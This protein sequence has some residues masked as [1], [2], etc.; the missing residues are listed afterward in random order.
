VPSTPP[1]AG[2][3]APPKLPPPRVPSIPPVAQS[4]FVPAR[5]ER[6]SNKGGVIAA[7][8]AAVLFAVAGL[9]GLAYLGVQRYAER[10]KKASIEKQEEIDNAEK[11]VLPSSTH[12]ATADLVDEDFKIKI[13]WPGKGAKVLRSDDASRLFPFSVGGILQEGGCSLVVTADYSPKAELDS[14]AKAHYATIPGRHVGE[15]KTEA[16]KFEGRDALRFAIQTDHLGMLATYDNLIFERDGWFL[17][18]VSWSLPNAK[19][20]LDHD[21]SVDLLEGTAAGRV[22]S[23]PTLNESRP[24]YRVRG[25]VFESAAHRLRVTAPDGTSLTTGVPALTI[26]SEAAVVVSAKGIE[27][28]VASQPLPPGPLEKHQEGLLKAAAEGMN[29]KVPAAPT[30]LKRVG[31]AAIDL[32]VL[33]GPAPYET[34][35]GSTALGGRVLAVRAVYAPSLRS[36]AEELIF[37]T[38]SSTD[39]LTDDAAAALR[40]ELPAIDPSRLVGPDR[41]LRGGKLVH[42][43]AGLTIPLPPDPTLPSLDDPWNTAPVSL[44]LRRPTW[45]IGTEVFVSP[46]EADV[47][48]AQRRVAAIVLGLSEGDVEAVRATAPIPGAARATVAYELASGVAGRV[49]IVTLRGNGHAVHVATNGVQKWVEDAE[50]D[51]KSFLT[52]ISFDRQLPE[53]DGAGGRLRHNRLGFEIELPGA[54]WTIEPARELPSH[55]WIA[56][57]EAK[58]EAGTVLL[59]CVSM[60]DVDASFMEGMLEQ[61]LLTK[62]IQVD[63]EA[64]KRADGKLGSLPARLLSWP[65]KAEVALARSETTHFVVLVEGKKIDK[66]AVFAGFKLLD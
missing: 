29:V 43:S 7:V 48:T 58:S 59:M 3:G 6:S 14:V 11:K 51:T 5:P 13:K 21:K 10:S 36:E 24:L 9:G 54:G 39:V 47:L 41:A 45:G 38:L 31:S 62:L 34:M 28:G 37:K 22:L 40:R 26:D 60:E 44:S 57:Y 8:I 18:I 30:A 65:K 55:P 20:S 1:P 16:V 2:L 56:A 63:G 61:G 53:V 46:D 52:G 32:Y 66:D 25:N 15:P 35:Y 19:C 49:D 17:R 64:P 33:E 50:A 4:P 42:F 27:L 23:R 12:D